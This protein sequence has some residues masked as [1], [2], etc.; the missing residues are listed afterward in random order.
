MKGCKS[1]MAGE[2]RTG[3]IHSTESFGTVDGPGVRLVIF[4]Q[5]CPMRCKYCHNPDS[6]ALSG[7]EEIS[8]EELQKSRSLQKLLD[9][10]RKSIGRNNRKR[11]RAAAAD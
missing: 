2:K 11:R 6:W 9:R 10:Q 7:G 8:S 3:R 4:F 1:S 5:G